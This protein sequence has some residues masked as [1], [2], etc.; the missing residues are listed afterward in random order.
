MPVPVDTP[1]LPELVVAGA[2]RSLSLAVQTLP[3]PWSFGQAYSGIALSWFLSA[4]ITTL[5]PLSVTWIWFQSIAT[6]FLPMPRKPPTPTTTRCTLPLESSITE[7]ILPTVLLSAWFWMLWPISLWASI[8]VLFEAIGVGR[9]VV[10]GGVVVVGLVV[11]CAQAGT[12]R[13]TARGLI[14]AAL[15]KMQSP[16][17]FPGRPP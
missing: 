8:W 4:F 2:R 17:L 15:F 12:A 11:V 7:S 14:S 1:L 6:S 16:P 10:A 9:V 3:R 5:R 13:G